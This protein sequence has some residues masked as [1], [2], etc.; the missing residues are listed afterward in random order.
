MW[1][2]I[3]ILVFVISSLKILEIMGYVA[4]SNAKNGLEHLVCLAYSFYF[5]NTLI[6]S[7]TMISNS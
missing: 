1:Q 3:G 2:I 7:I 5:F 4:K 6:F